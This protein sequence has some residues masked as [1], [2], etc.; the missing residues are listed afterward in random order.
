MRIVLKKLF[1]IPT[2][3]PQQHS[4]SMKDNHNEELTSQKLRKDNTFYETISCLM[5]DECII[6]NKEIKTAISYMLNSIYESSNSL[7][8]E[9]EE[10]IYI[11]I[12]STAKRFFISYTIHHVVKFILTAIN[13]GSHELLIK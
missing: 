4:I 5:D 1:K 6:D 7:Q 8:A 10:N 9:Y 2:K 13:T 3:Q 11:F 12:I